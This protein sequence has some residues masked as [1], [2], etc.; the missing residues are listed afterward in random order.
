MIDYSG[1]FKESLIPIFLPYLAGGNEN[2]YLIQ[3]NSNAE[4]PEA[5]YATILIM[6]IAGV[7][8]IDEGYINQ[9]GQGVKQDEDITIRI[10]TFGEGAYSAAS[11]L[12]KALEFQSV[13]QSLG[14][15]G[16]SFRSTT[17]ILDISALSQA[18]R[19]ERATFNMVLGVQDGNLFD[20]TPAE[21]GISG[22]SNQDPDTVPIESVDITTTAYDGGEIVYENTLESTTNTE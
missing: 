18:V 13:T 2:Y 17:P 22:Q 21:D 9:F 11:R 15:V 16:V 19:E 4:A 12:R 1:K 14:E 8:T 5:S 10:N 7:G 6:M 3:A 20:G